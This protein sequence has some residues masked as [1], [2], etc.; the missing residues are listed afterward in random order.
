MLAGAVRPHRP[1]VPGADEGNLAPVSGEVGFDV[2]GIFG[3]LVEV[4]VAGGVETTFG[5]FDF[6]GFLP[7]SAFGS[8]T[9]TIAR[10]KTTAP[11]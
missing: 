11:E 6:L 7:S 4:T 10:E 9:V 2:G 5:F 8:S 3:E 1:D